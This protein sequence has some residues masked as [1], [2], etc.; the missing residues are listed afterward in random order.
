[1]KTTRTIAEKKM[2]LALLLSLFVAAAIPFWSVP[3][4]KGIYS[5]AYKVEFGPKYVQ[6]ASQLK[7]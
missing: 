3:I 1:M 4:W 7:R 6:M 5:V 2:R